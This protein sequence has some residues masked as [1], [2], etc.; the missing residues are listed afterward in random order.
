[1]TTAAGH[2][3]ISHGS[4]NRDEANELSAFLEER[5]VKTWIAP[6]DVRPGMDYSEQLQAAIEE[7]VAFVVLVTDMA[8]KSPYVRAETEMAFSTHKPI[9]PV[10]T[11]EIKPAAGLALFLKI[12][13]WTDAFGK[14]RD[15]SMDRLALELQT[16]SGI[17]PGDRPAPPPAAPPPTAP[18][19]SPLPVA[20]AGAPGPMPAPSPDEE[21]LRAAIGPNADTYLARWRTMD[22]KASP[23]SWNWP[24][25]LASVYW[26]AYRKLWLPM[27]GLALAFVLLSVL[28]AWDPSLGKITLILS[29][30]L[31]FVTGTFGN[32]L[33]RRRVGT[34][35]AEAAG[36]GQA[37]ALTQLQTRGGVSR[38]A[39]IGAVAATL[40]LVA[41]AIA[42]A[43]QN[44]P[45]PPTPTPAPIDNGATPALGDKPA[46]DGMAPAPDD[47]PIDEQ[48]PMDQEPMP[49]EQPPVDYQGA[50]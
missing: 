14:D 31:T 29:I 35:N 22:A 7:C 32:H 39:L 18:P 2:V 40:V 49:D 12:R 5:G 16:L 25:C 9:F 17:A 3:F 36:L 44:M 37:E 26:F 15:G 28:G 10:R 41:V 8:N 43:A 42:F 4:E 47:Y 20:G 45:T 24:A 50:E 23:L 33:C 46:D 19:P 6:R 38:P 13:H 21:R 27:A 11:S 48:Q 1:M 34:L 30:L